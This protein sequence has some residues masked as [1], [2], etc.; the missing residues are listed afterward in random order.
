M[1]ASTFRQIIASFIISLSA[2]MSGSFFGWPSPVAQILR[3]ERKPM[4]VTT[5]EESWMVTCIEIGNLL[6]PLP[7]G[8]LMD[9]VGRRASLIVSVPIAI[10]GWA[11]IRCTKTVWGLYVAR[12]LHGCAMAVAY[13]VVPIYVGEIADDDKRGSLSL[14]FQGMI[15]SGVLLVY[16]VGWMVSY[17][18][19]AVIMSAIPMLSVI[20]LTII[21]ESPHYLMMK[22][23]KDRAFKSLK[24]LRS[25]DNEAEI[26][27][28]LKSMTNLSSL[29]STPD[30]LLKSSGR[31]LAVVLV[32]STCQ[33]FTGVGA[34]ESYASSAF[35]MN[36]NRNAIALG[37]VA[38]SS[39]LMSAIIIGRFGRRPLLL[40]SCVGCCISHSIA[41]YGM[42]SGEQNLM[43]LGAL[44]GVMFFANAGIM[45]LVAA[46]VCE[47]FPTEHRAQAN[48]ITQFVMTTA[49]LIS[50][51]IYQPINEAYGVYS[52]YVL[53]AA[54]G[55]FTTVFVYLVIPETKGLSFKEV[56]ME[57][58]KSGLKSKVVQDSKVGQENKAF[59][60]TNGGGEDRKVSEVGKDV[61][62]D[63]DWNCCC[64]TIKHGP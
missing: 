61:S 3:S 43:V 63:G 44:A 32:M 14:F 64:V 35:K 28:E 53:F 31:V 23:E 34:L 58:R 57:L 6:T 60:G 40:I 50:L 56:E 4:N 8:Y 10:T 41:A 45:P 37:L 26:E 36:G 15:S 54:V 11:L 47:Y 48:G 5:Y 27:T 18:W 33:I 49:S 13:T 17:D 51:K 2:L 38:L 62:G 25:T 55:A 24:W 7:T 22:G 19:L 21:P 52:N 16:V 39:D 1:H 59:E 30:T 20:L 9:A 12:I 29:N 42:F 46:I